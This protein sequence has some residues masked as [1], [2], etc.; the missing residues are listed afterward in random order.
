MV[1]PSSPHPSSS[2]ITAEDAVRSAGTH[3]PARIGAYFPPTTS[4]IPVH[5]FAH[6]PHSLGASPKAVGT[7]ETWTGFRCI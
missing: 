2:G 3:P 1:T 6:G 4:P 7:P 5:V